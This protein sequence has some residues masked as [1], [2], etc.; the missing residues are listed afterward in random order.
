M[1][2]NKNHFSDLTANANMDGTVSPGVECVQDNPEVFILLSPSVRNEY[3]RTTVSIT[4][5]L[6]LA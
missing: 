1:C 4:S 6:T 3:L 2:Q 5:S